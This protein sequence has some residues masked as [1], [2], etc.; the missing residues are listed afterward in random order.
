MSKINPIW[1]ILICLA[2]ASCKT[3]DIPAEYNYRVS[4]I[5]N[6]PFGCWME[7]KLISHDNLLSF[8]NISG[9]LLSVEKDSVYLLTGDGTVDVFSEL[10]VVSATLYIHKNQLGTYMAVTGLL[11]LPNMIGVATGGEFAGYFLLIALPAAVIGSV[12]AGIEGKLNATNTLHYPGANKISDMKKY[13]RFPA[14]IPPGI[15]FRLLFL[16]KNITEGRR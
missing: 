15:D 2:A 16:K 1:I 10:A 7:L 12:I 14:G 13:S 9:E 8:K 4:E 5:Q 11:I 6:N 3:A